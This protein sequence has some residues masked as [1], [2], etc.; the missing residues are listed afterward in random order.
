MLGLLVLLNYLPVSTTRKRICLYENRGPLVLQITKPLQK[1]KA[2][3]MAY[4]HL[5]DMVQVV[6]AIKRLPPPEQRRRQR[7]ET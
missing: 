7:G 4:P 5:V 1:V 2:A 6:E 3:A